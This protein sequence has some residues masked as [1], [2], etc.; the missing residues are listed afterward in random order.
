[1]MDLQRAI[2]RLLQEGSLRD[3]FARNPSAAAAGLDLEPRDCAAFGRLVP[4]DVEFQ[5]RVLMRK[6]FH[7]VR[8]LVPMTCENLGDAAWPRFVAYARN[9]SESVVA[10]DALAFCGAEATKVSALERQRLEFIL[11]SHRFAYHWLSKPCSLQI[12]LRARG[13][14]HERIVS[15]LSPVKAKDESG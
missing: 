9:H 10:R 3:E 8:A 2:A 12:L 5:A 1:M 4:E 7:A 11:A 13:K 15:L 14:I 6:R